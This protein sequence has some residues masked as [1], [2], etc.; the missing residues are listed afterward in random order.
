MKEAECWKSYIS[1][2]SRAHS[3]LT[4]QT[5]LIKTPMKKNISPILKQPTWVE[6]ET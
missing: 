4:N 6:A 2:K 5:S 1:S 3:W